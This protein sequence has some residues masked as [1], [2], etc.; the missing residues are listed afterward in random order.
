MP[1]PPAAAC[2]VAWGLQG[3]PFLFE[4]KK[5]TVFNLISEQTTQVSPCP[6]RSPM[7]LLLL[8]LCFD[9]L[10]AR[11]CAAGPAASARKQGCQSPPATAVARRR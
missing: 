7:W 1:P 10:T 8:R 9:G 5:D 3:T 4:G 11:P 6:A 2:P